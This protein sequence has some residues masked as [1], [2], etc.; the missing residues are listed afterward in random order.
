MT[1][2]DKE[3]FESSLPTKPPKLHPGVSW[4]SEGIL[5]RKSNGGSIDP[6]RP[7]IQTFVSLSQA[8]VASNEAYQRHLEETDEGFPAFDEE[9]ESNKVNE[10][11]DTYA[12]KSP[13]R[14]RV[15]DSPIWNVARDRTA[16][17]KLVSPL[18]FLCAT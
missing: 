6:A 7:G 11:M 14:L 4:A 5:S 10:S 1:S 12:A 3:Y 2:H 18:F 16:L 15:I 8:A 13:E 9:V 17:Y